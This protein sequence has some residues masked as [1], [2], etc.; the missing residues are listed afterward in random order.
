[1]QAMLECERDFAELDD[2]PSTRMPVGLLGHHNGQ[3]V[4]LCSHVVGLQRSRSSVVPMDRNVE[5]DLAH[6]GRQRLR[7]F[8][9]VA[10]ALVAGRCVARSA[11]AR[12]NT[13]A[14]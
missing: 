6:V 8:G 12:R 1:M 7:G 11:C 13:Q 2:K 4:A 10:R 5:S 9:R 14:R 3:C